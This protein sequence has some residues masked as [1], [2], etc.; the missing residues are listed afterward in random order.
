MIAVVK[1]QE[2]KNVPICFLKQFLVLDPH[3]HTQKPIQKP[4]TTPQRNSPVQHVRGWCHRNGVHVIY[5]P[6]WVF[7]KIVVPQNGWFIMENPIKMDDLGVP[8]FSETPWWCW[9]CFVVGTGIWPKKWN[10]CGPPSDEM[11]IEI[12][13]P[14]FHDP[15]IF[16]V[17]SP[18][19][20]K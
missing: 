1:N 13:D 15:Y 9:L 2:K 12:H 19:I 4:H 5:E 18:Y 8:L 11:I 16:T 20:S 10:E 17:H 14:W 6:W 7:P 3:H